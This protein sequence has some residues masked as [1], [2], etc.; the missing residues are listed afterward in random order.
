MDPGV[1]SPLIDF[2]R[3]GEVA[4][5]VRLLAAQG[6]LAPR[7][8]E[9]LALLVLLSDDPD[10]E[11]ARATAQTLDALP[12]AALRS[13]L[14]RSDA[15]TEMRNFFAARGI[16]IE[17]AASSPDRAPI[18]LEEP[19][20]DTLSELPEDPG[21]A[22][23]EHK[24]L[25][26]LSV[27]ERMKLAMKGTREQRSVLVRDSNKLVA[28]AVLSSPKVNE[29][30]IETFTKMGNVSEDVL[31]IIG[32]NRGWT[33]NYGVMLGLCRHPKT[34]PAIAMSFVQRLNEK[35]LKALATDRNA[36]DGLRLL[37][38]KMLTKGKG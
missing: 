27:L 25:S 12:D 1:R 21:P 20:L 26:S 28:A 3:R 11:I 9:Q 4:R 34:P 38:K 35:D 6:A 2:F 15:P 10:P 19:L 22:D 33:K 8:Q 16:A 7:A 32:T 31:R 5:D 14:S 30:E 17:A 24:A 18:N 36:K 13:F 29:S 37:A 23:P